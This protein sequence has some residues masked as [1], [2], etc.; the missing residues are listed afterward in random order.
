MYVSDISRDLRHRSVAEFRSP[1]AGWHQVVTRS[2]HLVLAVSGDSWDAGKQRGDAVIAEIEPGDLV[3]RWLRQPRLPRLRWRP[4]RRSRLQA[5]LR[6]VI[7]TGATQ[8]RRK[9]D[10]P[11]NPARGCE[12][13]DI[14]VA[15]GW[16][17]LPRTCRNG[18]SARDRRWQAAGF[19]GLGE[20]VPCPKPLGGL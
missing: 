4:R 3:Q 12:F 13:H 19:D 10:A 1:A 7:P 18:P 8:R 11:T 16:S 15:S 6:K 9:S 17:N 20:T 5:Q 2:I 14:E